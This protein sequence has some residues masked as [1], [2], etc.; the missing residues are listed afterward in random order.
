MKVEY[1]RETYTFDRSMTVAQ[2]LDE[3]GIVPE[4]VIVAV[5]GNLATH[6][7]RIGE[8]DEVEIVRAISGG[9][10]RGPGGPGP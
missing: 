2:F 10:G 7:V 9:G 4:G 3:L 8:E 5:N 6:D 1:G